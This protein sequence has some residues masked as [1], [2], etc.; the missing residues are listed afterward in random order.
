MTS[1]SLLIN[2]PIFIVGPGR[3][4]TTLV[5]SLLSSHSMISV[6]PETQYMGWV[7]RREDLLGA[8]KDFDSFWQEYTS[9]VRFKDLDID[10]GRCLELIDIQGDKSFQNIFRAVLSTYR[11]RT[12]KQLVG[13]KSPSHI[14]YLDI[15]LDWF[16]KAKVIILQRDP[17][18]IISSQLQTPYVLE[19]ITPASLQRGVFTSSRIREAIRY[20]NDWS[21]IYTKILPSFKDRE[22]IHITVYE[23]LVQ[24]PKKTIGGLCQF[25]NIQF[26]EQMLCN[27]KKETV[28]M[29]AGKTPNKQLEEWRR[30]HHARSL[31]PVSA[32]SLD[33]WKKALTEFEISIVEAICTRGMQKYCYKASLS[34]IKRLRGY[35]CLQAFN[36]AEQLESKTRETFRKVRHKFS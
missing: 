28:P 8:P 22:N 9:W 24:N 12:G 20:A 31:Q 3:S 32:D 7:D 26:E 25:L 2:S 4:G 23:D 19:R 13:E 11:E 10:P 6:T 36:L 15:L 33:K 1:K 17:R 16:P 21:N 5:R 27:R 35:F 18:A 30:K 14:H 34:K 29:P